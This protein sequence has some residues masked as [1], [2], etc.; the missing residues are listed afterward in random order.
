MKTLITIGGPTCVGKTEVAHYIGKILK[1]EIISADARQIYKYL[2]IGTAK[3]PLKLREEL[4][5]WM[6]DIILPHQRFSAADYKREAE[7]IIEKVKLPILVGG[8]GLY[9][10]SI[11]DGLFISPPA[12]HDLRRKFQ[13]EYSGNQLYSKLKEVDEE[14]A[15]RIH[16]HD[17]R[18][19]IRALEV[20]YQSGIPISKLQKEFT[21]IT[22]R[23]YHIISIYLTSS[24]FELRHKIET[25]TQNM[26]D[27]G[28]IEE[29]ERVLSMYDG[30]KDLAG[31]EAI[32]YK[33]VIAYLEGK[34]KTKEGLK[35][36]IIKRT[37]DYARRQ[38]RWFS[39]YN[40]W[41][42]FY[43]HQ[44]EEILDY[45]NSQRNNHF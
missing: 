30:N 3:P 32:G 7:K 31:F 1:G 11:K 20:Y 4:N 6:L 12:D 39:K 9:I 21:S 37:W 13:E 45:I 27:T 2:D 43:P 29:T 26:L 17:K 44:I 15:K 28:L 33:E 34:I 40:G 19:I 14:A 5:Y 38:I 22:K 10:R 42:V 18:R 35:L 16:P 24:P 41:K 36:E 25:R 23:D 8:T